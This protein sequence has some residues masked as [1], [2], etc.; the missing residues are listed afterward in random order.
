MRHSENPSAT[1]LTPDRKDL[2]MFVEEKVGKSAS[3][4][5]TKPSL[6]NLEYNV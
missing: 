5:G 2:L 6:E 3:Q 4:S 1:I